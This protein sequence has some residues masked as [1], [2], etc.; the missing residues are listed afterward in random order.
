MN[1]GYLLVRSPAKSAKEEQLPLIP[2]H[3]DILQCPVNHLCLACVSKLEQIVRNYSSEAIAQ[4]C[5]A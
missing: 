5:G 2:A 4:K 1:S 3:A